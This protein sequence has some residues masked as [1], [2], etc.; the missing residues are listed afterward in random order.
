[1]DG[2]NGGDDEAAPSSA[3]ADFMGGVEQHV[4]NL[5]KETNKAP[6]DAWDSWRAF[7]AAI[8]WTEPW[9]IVLLSFHVICLG[10]AFFTRKLAGFQCV[11]FLIICTLVFLA[12]K[13]NTICSQRWQEFTTQNYF[14]KNGVFA[15]TMFSGPLLA[16]ATIILVRYFS[17]PAIHNTSLPIFLKS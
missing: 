2:T 6:K 16:I 8:Q 1:M 9:I 3:F 17:A 10:L 12:E 15:S 4:L 13:I 5:V 11:M 7:A 14:D